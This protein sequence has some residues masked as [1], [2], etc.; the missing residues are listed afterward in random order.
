MNKSLSWL[1]RFFCLCSV[2]G[3]RLLLLSVEFVRGELAMINNA[4]VR[5]LFG[6][7]LLTQHSAQRAH[8]ESISLS[9]FRKSGTCLVH[10]LICFSLC[11]WAVKLPL[12]Y[13]FC[14]KQTSWKLL[15]YP[16]THTLDVQVTSVRVRLW[17]FQTCSHA[18]YCLKMVLLS[19]FCSVCVC[20]FGSVPIASPL[21]VSCLK[22]SYSL[23]F[24]SSFMFSVS[25]SLVQLI[26]FYFPPVCTWLH[27]LSYAHTFLSRLLLL[28]FICFADFSSC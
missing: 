26:L 27:S 2:P 20:K 28:L 10:H 7:P 9:F 17:I 22:L 24:P 15:A 16:R 21:P 14:P 13:C 12:F 8:I 5:P 6:H 11:V 18:T 19:H 3:S 23:A 4:R 25:R 1:C